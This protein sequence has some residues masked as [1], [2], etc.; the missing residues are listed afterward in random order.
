MKMI[1]AHVQY[2]SAVTGGYCSC[3]HSTKVFPVGYSL[4]TS[5]DALQ[6]E[7]EDINLIQIS[8]KLISCFQII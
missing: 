6:S 4:A 8:G 1:I 2:V 3:V 5:I 7:E